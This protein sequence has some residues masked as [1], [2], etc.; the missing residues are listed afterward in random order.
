[1]WH[2]SLYVFFPVKE[3]F[4]KNLA[5]TF[6]AQPKSIITLCSAYQ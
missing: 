1:M 3:D 6:L 4:C 2:I 5:Y